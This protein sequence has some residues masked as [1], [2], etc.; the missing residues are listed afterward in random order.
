M[1]ENRLEINFVTKEH[2]G[3]YTCIAEDHEGNTMTQN[4]SL[5]VIDGGTGT[6]YKP[7]QYFS[8][9]FSLALFFSLVLH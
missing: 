8:V 9:S 7:S 1:A 6:A 4:I 5:I 2:T 3:V